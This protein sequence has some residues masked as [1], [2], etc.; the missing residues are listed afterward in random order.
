[1]DVQMTSAVR[2]VS[3]AAVHN[4]PVVSALLGD[5]M[6]RTPGWSV[7]AETA[8]GAVL[9][10]GEPC[11]SLA[12]VWRDG[13]ALGPG[14]VALPLAV[15]AAASPLTGRPLVD[16]L[17]ATGYGGAPLALLTDV[18]ERL[19]PSL[20]TLLELGVA[21]EAHGQN[22]LAVVAAGRIVRLLYR[23]MGGL[24]VSP[25]RL[26]RHGLSAPSLRGDLAED[27]PVRLRHKVY[28]AAVTTVLG[29]LVATLDRHGVA[30]DVAWARVAGVVRAHRDI[31]AG[32]LG[33]S[34]VDSL[35]ADPLPLKA[36]TAMRL[37][38]DPL[39]DRWARVPNPMCGLS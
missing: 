1:V 9:V 28:A 37:A 19:L 8:A 24:R 20:L 35:L 33:R 13:P 14:E 4:G 23:D 2:T 16:E 38:D 18:A 10:D 22:V 7:L 29:E 6:A 12:M 30:A 36:M 26:G 34:D 32:P 15:L 17:V 21:L 39:V 11:R 3:A 31:G 5:L 27:D 25:A